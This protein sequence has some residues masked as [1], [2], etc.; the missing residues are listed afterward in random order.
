MF[1]YGKS[2]NIMKTDLQG[3]ILWTTSVSNENGS[4][5]VQKKEN[6]LITN[7]VNQNGEL[8]YVVIDLENGKITLKAD[9]K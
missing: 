4:Y 6:T 5:I 8:F 1:A 2:D 3:N 9:S 7:G